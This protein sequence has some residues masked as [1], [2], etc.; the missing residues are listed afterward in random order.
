M[1]IFRPLIPLPKPRV[2]SFKSTG[3]RVQ[4]DL[5]TFIF[6]FNSQ[7]WNIQKNIFDFCVFSSSTVHYK[8]HHFLYN[9]EKSKKYFHIFP[10]FKHCPKCLQQLACL[11]LENEVSKMLENEER[12]NRLID[13]FD[14][15]FSLLAD[16]PYMGRARDEL[17]A[18]IRSFP[19]G[20]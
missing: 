17:V 1:T 9:T 12:G 6:Q 2:L 8:R 18:G 19:S 15:Q 14:H 7:F 11:K 3:S 10:N 20:N 13:R 5:N 4:I 16:N